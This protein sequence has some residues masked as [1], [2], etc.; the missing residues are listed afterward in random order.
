MSLRNVVAVAHVFT[1]DLQG[2]SSTEGGGARCLAS[3]GDWRRSSR[4]PGRYA[5][6]AATGWPFEI[7]RVYFGGGSGTTVSIRTFHLPPSRT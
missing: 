3:S 5:R 2:S 6:A 7:E 1:S 4:P